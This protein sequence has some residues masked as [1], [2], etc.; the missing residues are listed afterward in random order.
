[1]IVHSTW[2]FHN[3]ISFLFEVY[4]QKISS[5]PKYENISDRKIDQKPSDMEK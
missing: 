5:M 4:I 3:L 1:M 2:V